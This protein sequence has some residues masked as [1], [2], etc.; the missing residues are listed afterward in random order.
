M[1]PFLKPTFT[2]P[3]D[4]LKALAKVVHLHHAFQIQP[5]L[6]SRD[7]LL[8]AI[9]SRNALVD[10]LFDAQG[11]NPK[12]PPAWGFVMFPPLGHDAKHLRLAYD[13]YQEPFANSP[14]NWDTKAM[15]LAPLPGA[16]RLSVSLVTGPITWDSPQWERS[17]VE[18]VSN[19]LLNSRKNG[20]VG[21]VPHGATTV[22]AIADAGHLYLRVE[23]ALPKDNSPQDIVDNY[24]APLA[25]KDVTYRFTVGPKANSKQDAANGFNIV[26]ADRI[27]RSLW[28]ASN[29]TK[30]MDDRNDFGELAFEARNDNASSNRDAILMRMRTLHQDRKWKE[31]IEQFASEDFS[32]WPADMS[33]QASE[34]FHLRGQIYSFLKDGP[35]AEADL[36]ASVKLAPNNAAF[37]LT[38]ADNCTNNSKDDELA[39][40]AYRQAF[41]ITGQGNGWQPLTA[42]IAIA[43]LL[44]DQVKTDEAL[45]VLKPY[46][47]LK[48]LPPIWRI[49]ML[50]AYGHAYAAQ[51]NEP[52][53]LAKFREALEL[54]SKP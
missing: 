11:A 18:H 3:F 45:A 32:T 10:S 16:K 37:W 46:G 4:Y 35:K 14:M 42:T 22:R 34:A 24:L 8:D 52:E 20:H 36:K 39:L 30:V 13:G 41:A 1:A 26:A 23:A 5:D 31:L 6:T 9:D 7:R 28:T 2:E 44:T 27:E 48:D 49:K 33:N 53:S 12:P 54:E 29:S 19:V 51:G 17:T 40:A 21:N 15:R 47:D 50:R 25:R 43:R 38:L